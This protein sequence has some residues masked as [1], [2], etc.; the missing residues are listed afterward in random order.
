MLLAIDLDGPLYDDRTAYLA[1]C[2]LT[3]QFLEKHGVPIP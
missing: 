2:K 1:Y 3:E